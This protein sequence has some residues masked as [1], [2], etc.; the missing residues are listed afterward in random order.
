MS[1]VRVPAA[2][3]AAAVYVE[4]SKLMPWARN[5]RRNEATVPEV[6]KSIERLARDVLAKRGV[7]V[8]EKLTPE[9]LVHGWGAPIVARLD[10]GEVIAGHSRLKAAL[11]LRLAC[12]WS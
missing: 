1:E 10:N 6:C 5:P 12:R 4:L 7:E 2:G 3:D 9:Q 8:G 11:R